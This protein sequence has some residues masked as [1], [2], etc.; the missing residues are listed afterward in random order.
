MTRLSIISAAMLRRAANCACSSTI[1]AARSIEAAFGTAW[2][3]V[4]EA[5]WGALKVACTGLSAWLVIGDV[6]RTAAPVIAAIA[7]GGMAGMTEA[8][9][10]RDIPEPM[11]KELV[12]LLQGLTGR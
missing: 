7:L 11:E 9:L 6:A 1:V 10:L 5:A 3:G 4:N 8:L 2:A 12:R